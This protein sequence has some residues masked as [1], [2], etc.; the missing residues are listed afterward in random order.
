MEFFTTPSDINNC[1]FR[2]SFDVRP[3]YNTWQDG[4]VRSPGNT[5]VGPCGLSITPLLQ[6]NHR[7]NRT[8]LYCF[9]WGRPPQSSLRSALR[10]SSCAVESEADG[11]PAAAL[12]LTWHWC[13]QQRPVRSPRHRW[14]RCTGLWGAAAPPAPSPCPGPASSGRGAG[15]WMGAVLLSAG[16]GL[17]ASLWTP[18]AHL[19]WCNLSF[20]GKDEKEKKH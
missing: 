6:M 5:A 14:P 1:L 18:A 15:V 2:N 19:A 7:V 20:P 9:N 13:S 17:P 10:R 4:R 3:N 12:S 11:F 16:C 8:T